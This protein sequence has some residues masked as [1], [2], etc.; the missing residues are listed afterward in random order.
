MKIM[1]VTDAWEPQVNGVVRTLKSTSRELTALG[2]RVEL[3]TPLEFRTIP[4]PTYPEIRLSLFPYARL[5]ARIDEFAPD[6]LH[7]ATEGPLGMAARRYARKHKLPF[8][9]AYH[10]RF[11]EY[12]QARFGIPL[13]A[14]YRFLRWF[15][16]ASLAV[17]APT[18]VVK[19]DLEAFGFDNV[20]LWTRGVDL[21]IFEPMESK[22]LNTARPIFLYVGRVAIEKNVEAFLKLDLPGSKWVAGEG[23]ALAELKSRYPE[24]NYL[25]VLTQAE[26]AKVYAAADVFVF[27]S[28]TDTFGLVLLEAL[29]CG[30]PVAAYPVTGPVD[31]LGGGGAGAMNEDL[32]EACLEALKIDRAEARAWAERFSWRAASEQF[33]SHLKPLPKTAS[34]QPQGAAV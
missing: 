1:I 16:G 7:I 9:T 17:M 11:P 31:V 6:A 20:V 5:R 21:D 14:T 32:R 26:L 3:L 22:V 23:P 28:K 27:P 19:Q 34:S 13:S 33:A 2:H 30:T 29:A 25:G 12:V 15:H 24:A 4:C 8:T 18:P 10:T